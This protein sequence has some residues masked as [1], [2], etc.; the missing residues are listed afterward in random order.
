M[1]RVSADWL[2]GL[3]PITSSK[4]CLKRSLPHFSSKIS[5]LYGKKEKKKEKEKN[6]HFYS[7]PVRIFD[8]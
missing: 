3:F 5:H 7:M 1:T 8:N 4:N 2:T 6:I